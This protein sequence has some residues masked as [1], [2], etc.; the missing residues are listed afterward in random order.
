MVL[1]NIIIVWLL[2]SGIGSLVMWAGVRRRKLVWWAA[3][4]V[5]AAFLIYNAV[6][7][8]GT[9]I[10]VDLFL[11]VPVLLIVVVKAIRER[12]PAA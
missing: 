9:N 8:A 5:V 7:P 6:L 12:R 3:G 1:A 10:R 11:T 2:L 4:N